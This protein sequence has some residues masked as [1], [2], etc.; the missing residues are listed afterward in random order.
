MAMCVE[1]VGVNALEVGVE[2]MKIGL[3]KMERSCVKR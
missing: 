1:P 3:V 2:L